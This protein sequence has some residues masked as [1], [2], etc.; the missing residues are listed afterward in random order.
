[1]V[2]A[3]LVGLV[4]AASGAA[5]GQATNDPLAPEQWALTKINASAAWARSTG[6]GVFIGVVDSGVDLAHEDLAGKV[7]ASV[8]CVG[9]NGHPATCAGSA[10]DD[11]GHGTHVSGIAAA[12]TNN[13]KGVAAVA[14]GAGLLVAKAL[15]NQNGQEQG[16]VADIT[17][18][19]EWVVDH[20]ARV[21]NLSLGSEVQLLAGV[22][23]GDTSLSTGIEYA[24]QHGAVPVIASGNSTFLSTANFG[25]MDTIVVGATGPRDEMASYSSSM[26]N[27]KWQ[28]V[29][30]GGDDPTTACTDASQCIVSTYF[31]P[32]QPTEHNQYALLEGTSMAAPHVAGVVALLLGAHLSAAQAVNAVLAGADKRVSCGSGCAGRL[33]AAGALAA[34]GLAPPAAPAPSGPSPVTPSAGHGPPAGTAAAV[35]H[36]R[37]GAG[38]VAPANATVTGPVLGKATPTSTAAANEAIPDLGS[39]PAPSGSRPGRSAP[40]RR[41]ATGWVWAATALAVALVGAVVA[42]LNR[43]IGPRKV[44][45]PPYLPPT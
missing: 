27:A 41:T 14:P 11:D 31:D 35:G 19:I 40:S 3:V 1:M 33:D 2:A 28:L 4:T 25:S 20:G 6:A 30:S 17:A 32:S 29:A 24:W 36:G 37:G 45:P 15:A 18:G 9:S 13:G 34:A 8:N 5:A 43:I 12:S 44:R 7:V 10:Q 21:V 22:F 23:G 38:A 39:A 26:G 42:V 16:T